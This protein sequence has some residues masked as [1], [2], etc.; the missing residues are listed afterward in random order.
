MYSCK[1][2][3]TIFIHK[4]SQFQNKRIDRFAICFPF[5]VNGFCI[6]QKKKFDELIFVLKKKCK[7]H[8]NPI[9]HWHNF[10]LVSSKKNYLDEIRKKNGKNRSKAKCCEANYLTCNIPVTVFVRLPY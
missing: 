1:Q 9:K 2:L 4:Y 5:D 10:K 8:W 7:E 6:N 3:I